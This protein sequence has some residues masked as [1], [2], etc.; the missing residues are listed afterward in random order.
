[1]RE[2]NNA[3]LGKRTTDKANYD[4]VVV[5][6][7]QAVLATGRDPSPI[8]QCTGHRHPSPASSP[9]LDTRGPG[10]TL[11]ANDLGH[12]FRAGHGHALR[13]VLGLLGRAGEQRSV[14]ETEWRFGTCRTVGG[15]IQVEHGQLQRSLQGSVSFHAINLRH[16]GCLLAISCAVLLL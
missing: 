7:E 4:K 15:V 2:N 14:E 10:H 5:T 13:Y 1:M 3:T 12:M 16:G 11:T 6:R 9:R 8:P